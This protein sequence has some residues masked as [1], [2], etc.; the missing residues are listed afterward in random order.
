MVLEI[1]YIYKFN[2]IHRIY[3]GT[4]SCTIVLD[5]V[6]DNFN[7]LH[8]IFDE[9]DN[10]KIITDDEV[11]VNNHKYKLKD[12]DINIINGTTTIRLHV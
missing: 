7:K 6:D 1:N 10:I 12:I 11:I 2:N 3:N 8:R 5:S 9:V 4:D